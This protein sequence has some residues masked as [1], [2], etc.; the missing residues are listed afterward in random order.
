MSLQVAIDKLMY[1]DKNAT[2]D[3]VE[4]KQELIEGLEE[5][6]NNNEDDEEIVF[7]YQ[8]ILEGLE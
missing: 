6:I 5:A 4:T 8:E 1:N 3:E 7:F 2:W